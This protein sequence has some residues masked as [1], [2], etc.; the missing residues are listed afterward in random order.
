M[1]NLFEFLRNNFFHVAPILIVGGFAIAIVL[2]RTRALVW[3]YPM[4]QQTHFFEKLRDLIMGDRLA[5]AI[6]LC[7]RY[8][9]K[10]VAHVVREA[11]LRAHQPEALIED[12]L[13]LAVSEA[14]QKITKRTQFLSTIANVSTLLGLFGTIIGLIHSF[15]AVGSATAQERS[16]LLAQGIS[17]AMN[18]TMLGLA[19]AIPCMLAF[20][21]LMNRTNR[22]TVEIEQSAIRVLDMIK[23]RY[24]AAEL[25]G[26]QDQKGVS[27]AV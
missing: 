2:E 23:Q 3:A 24:Y 19:V 5:D 22:L 6:S 17:T 4:N 16:A 26:S 10:P 8:R 21:F 15:E 14:A 25:E 11:L 13:Q 20:S 9:S 27:R 12:G 7:D 1:G 18:A